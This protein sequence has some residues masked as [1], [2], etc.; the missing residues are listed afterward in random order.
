MC[1]TLFGRVDD[2]KFKDLPEAISH[3]SSFSSQLGDSNGGLS[4][5]S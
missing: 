3:T 4:E 2:L 1:S 5:G